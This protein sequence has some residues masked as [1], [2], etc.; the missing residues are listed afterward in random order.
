VS[1]YYLVWGMALLAAALLLVVVEVFVP[2][3]GVIS[4]LALTAAVAGIVC[5]F[6]VNVLWGVIGVLMMLILWPLIFFFGLSIM[7]STH[8]G[9]K[10]LF[11]EGGKEE[12]GLGDDG[13]GS[14]TDPALRALIGQEA[15]ALT[16][17][18]PVGTI[19]VGDQKYDAL[20]EVSLIR[21]GTRVRITAIEDNQIKV[22]P[23]G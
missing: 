14:G 11:G 5:L 4:V 12:P 17:L 22:R 21:G 19:R 8:F 18:R 1:E 3:A 2:S 9:R 7:P 6:K 10:L 13:D 16:D 15:L 23:V 20:S